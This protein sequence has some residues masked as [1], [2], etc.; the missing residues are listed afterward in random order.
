MQVKKVVAAEWFLRFTILCKSFGRI[1]SG[2][3]LAI[4][5]GTS[6]QNDDNESEGNEPQSPTYFPQTETN[7]ESLVADDE[8]VVDVA[9]DDEIHNETEVKGNE[10]ITSGKNELSKVN[11]AATEQRQD[12][13]NI[14]KN[15]KDKKMAVNCRYLVRS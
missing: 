2:H 13:K 10:N 11:K 8:D 7:P 12:L 9:R 4:W 5:S 6:G 1:T 14:M 15:R 3:K